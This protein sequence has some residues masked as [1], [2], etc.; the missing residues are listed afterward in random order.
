[1]SDNNPTQGMIVARDVS[2]MTES[3]PALTTLQTNEGKKR[4]KR[5]KGK[6][7]TNKNIPITTV[8]H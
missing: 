5:E 2:I 1:M 8:I 6:K 4:G 3:D 7:K